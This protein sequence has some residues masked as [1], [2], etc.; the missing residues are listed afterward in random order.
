M[1]SNLFSGISV[2]AGLGSLATGIYALRVGRSTR[3]WLAT[4]A[5]ILTS[6][7]AP[8][9]EGSTR[10]SVSYRYTF[11]G[12]EYESECIRPI[13]SYSSF[14][15]PAQQIV[16]RYKATQQVIAFVNPAQ[17]KEACLEPGVQLAASLAFIVTGL[18]FFVFGAHRL[19]LALGFIEAE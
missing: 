15:R 19:L 10:A 9:P 13:S 5:T 3:S 6:R 8:G 11:A 4:P 14:T 17:P 2:L 16:G 7:L 1:L 12:A 18:V